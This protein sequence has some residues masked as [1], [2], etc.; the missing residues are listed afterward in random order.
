MMTSFSIVPSVGTLLRSFL[1]TMASLFVISCSDADSKAKKT[2][3][4]SDFAT[5]ESDETPAKKKAKELGIAGQDEI[6]TPEFVISKLP[7]LKSS[8]YFATKFEPFPEK[9]RSVFR[10]MLSSK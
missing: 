9:M 2:Q 7:S 1:L 5:T 4:A 3:T 8:E 10:R 6:S